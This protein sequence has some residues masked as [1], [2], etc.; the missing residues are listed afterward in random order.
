L[1]EYAGRAVVIDTTPDFRAQG[2][3][4]GLERL[5]GVVFTHSHADHILGLDDVRV[6]YFR[7]Q[8]PI[9]I[10][11]DAACMEAV[12][13]TFKYIFD[14]NYP[15]G[16]LAKLD[17]HLIEGPFDLEGLTIIPVPV[18]HGNLPILGFRFGDAAY[19][20]D[21]SSIPETSFRLLEGLEVVILDALRHKP[22][23]THLS[24]EQSLEVVERLKPRRAYFT[25]IAHDL[26]HEETNALL[27]PHVR[28]AY[29]G[30]KLEIKGLEPGVRTPES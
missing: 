27:P 16:G 15:Y 4:E 19:L 18:F 24:V 23:P 17:P 30:Q 26:A 13:R 8:K 1:L 6:F 12:C 3:R 5:D 11:A 22:H 28:V 20:T 25:H 21:V 9:P 2:L 7:Q 14:G 29:D 10:Y